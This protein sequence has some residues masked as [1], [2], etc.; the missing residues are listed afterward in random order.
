MDSKTYT[1]EDLKKKYGN[2]SAPSCEIIIG[3][4][5]HVDKGMSISKLEVELSATFEAG[6]CTFEIINGYNPSKGAYE[7]EWLDKVLL[8]GKTVEV[9]MGYIKRE[10][11]FYGFINSLTNSFDEE[12]GAVITVSCLDAKGAMMAGKLQ[13]FQGEKKLTDIVKEVISTYVS[14][15]VAKS[16][17]VDDILDVKRQI[18]VNCQT[19]YDF[20]VSLARRIN[21]EFFVSKSEICYVKPR[22]VAGPIIILTLGQNV[23]SFSREINLAHQVKEV[24]VIG[25]D[26]IEKKNI[27]AKATSISKTAGKM[28]SDSFSLIKKRVEEIY[29]P[30][31]RTKEEAQ[32]LAKS[33]LEEYS[34]KFITGTGECIGIPELIPGRFIK[35]ERFDKS[36]D[37]KYYLTRVTHSLSED[38]YFTSFEVGANSI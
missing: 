33:V 28:A 14:A 30:A 27:V 23:I 24:T 15:K 22:A 16:S 1:Y 17:K 29:D 35:M 38:G 21:F 7:K 13:K 31:V 5:S 10:T 11:V 9:K 34:M 4:T 8:P 26:E 6:G 18:F 3:G 20:L 12:N 37:G 2:F 25:N 36:I 32:A 19:D